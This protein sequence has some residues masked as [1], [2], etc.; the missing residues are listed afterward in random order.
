MDCN[1][2]RAWILAASQKRRNIMKL[3]FTFTGWQARPTQPIFSP[4]EDNNVAHYC[5]LQD[6]MVVLRE[7]FWNP[8]FLTDNS[9]GLLKRG[10]AGITIR[11]RE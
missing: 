6:I 2:N 8:E 10:S 11:D 1:A 9:W 5:S 7:Q 3:P 4:K